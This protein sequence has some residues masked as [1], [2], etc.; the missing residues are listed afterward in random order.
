LDSRPTLPKNFGTKK[1]W[2]LIRCVGVKANHDAVG[3]RVFVYV[4]NRRISGEV[5]TGSS[6]LSQNDPRIHVGLGDELTYDHI[7]VQ[8]PA[9]QRESF[10]GG[11]A[12]QIL[13]LTQA[14][15]PR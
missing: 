3:A 10:P 4:G 6:F 8:W 14:K 1:N 15:V 13:M 9:G 12:N 2:L 7:E 11:K 5:Q